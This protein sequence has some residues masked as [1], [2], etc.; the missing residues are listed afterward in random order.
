MT[1]KF[2]DI[3]TFELDWKE[4]NFNEISFEELKILENPFKIRNDLID[5]KFKLYV[6]KRWKHNV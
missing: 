1:S 3:N 6:K 5:K 2:L 4:S